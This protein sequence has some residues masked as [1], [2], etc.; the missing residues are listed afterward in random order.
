[1]LKEKYGK[2]SPSRKRPLTLSFVYSHPAHVWATFFGVGLLKPAPGTWGTVAG[3]LSYALYQPFCS[4][5]ITVLVAVVGLI[6]AIWACDRTGGDAGVMDHGSIV[7]DEVV[8][9]WFVL[10]FLPP[11]WSWWIAAVVVFRF[12]DILKVWPAGWLDRNLH[13]GFGVMMDDIMAAFY[14]VLTLI[15]WATFCL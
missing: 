3:M 7:I 14:T 2:D 5:E 11:K 12:F 4:F 8:A 9:M 15:V 13:G 10:P 6:L 1:M